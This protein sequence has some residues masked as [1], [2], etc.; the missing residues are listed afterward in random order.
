MKNRRINV[1]SLAKGVQVTIHNGRKKITARRFADID[2]AMEFVLLRGNRRTELLLT[3]RST[4]GGDKQP[5]LRGN[6]LRNL[7]AQ[8]L[9][10]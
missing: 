10:T 2:T 4:V 7:I 9:K 5:D 3:A 1:T 6:P 8:N